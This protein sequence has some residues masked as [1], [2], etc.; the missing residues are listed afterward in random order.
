MRSFTRAGLTFD[1]SDSGPDTGRAV[2]MLHGFPEDRH[3][4]DRLTEHL[5]GAGC[6]VLAPDQRGYSPD[7]RPIGRRPYKI[8]ELCADVLALADTAGLGAFDVVGHDWGAA[9]AW[10][11]A[12]RFPG[13]IRSLVALSMPHP[14]AF[15]ES[16]FRSDQALRSW[17][18]LAF[19]VP[20]LPELALRRAATRTAAFLVRDG[21]DPELAER[22]AARFAERGAMT[23]PLNWY[24]A[25][26]YD[27]SGRSSPVKV[28][29]LFVWGERDRSLNRW[30]AERTARYVKAPYRFEVIAGGSHWLP[31]TSADVLGPWINEHL[32]LAST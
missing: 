3:C 22:C 19:Q 12:G 18:M 16:L 23:G 20:A 15:A 10:A 11:L 14:R 30:A 17:Y 29:T 13:R 25:L 5:V 1:V 8:S 27:L 9:I 26:P 2:V 24:R 28:P 31:A 6:R 21:L 4:W 7:A 32:E